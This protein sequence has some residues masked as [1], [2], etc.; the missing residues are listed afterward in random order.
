MKELSL[1]EHHE[2]ILKI[3][4]DIDSFCRENNIKYSLASGTLLGAVRHGGFIPWDDDADIFMLRK[5]FERFVATYKGRNFQLLYSP[6]SKQ[7]FI[8]GG[9]AKVAD[10]CTQVTE[11]PMGCTYGVFVDIFPLDDV[12]IDRD[13]RKKHMHSMR[14]LT[15]RLYH[16]QKNDLLSIIKS[17]HHTMKQWWQRYL[18]FVAVQKYSGSGL[19]AHG[20]GAL[21]DRTVLDKTR[22]DTLAE[23]NFEGNNFLAFSDP[24]SYLTM[25]YG[26]DYMTPPPPGERESHGDK[27][28]KIQDGL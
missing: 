28:V 22:F 26:D 4:R 11:N 25:V 1:K 10:T 9:Y 24:H 27:F 3:L 12:P 20:F 23:I 2:V 17:H 8:V 6:D 16:R 7:K 13:E 21:N 19:A 15:N 18:D 14:R 5:D